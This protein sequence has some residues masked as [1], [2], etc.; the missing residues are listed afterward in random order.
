MKRTL[1]IIVF[2]LVLAHTAAVAAGFSV[3]AEADDLAQAKAA[4]SARGF[5]P[6]DAS[7]YVDT[8]DLRVILAEAKGPFASHAPEMA[9]FFHDGLYLGTDTLHPSDSVALVGSSS[10]EVTLVYRTW[11]PADAHCC[12]TGPTVHVRFDWTGTR[13]VPVDPI[14]TDAQ[15]YAWTSITPR[16]RGS[17][18][19]RSGDLR[20]APVTLDGVGGVVP[21]MTPQQ[22]A[23]RWGVHVSLGPAVASPG[24]QTATITKR[25]IHGYAL[26]EGGRFGAIFFDRGA[27]TPSGITIGSRVT[28]LLRVYGPRLHVKPHAYVAGGHYYFLTRRQPP[29]WRLRFDSNARGIITQIVFG[30]RAAGYIEGCA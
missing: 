5:H 23:V 3:G 12:P 19:T 28:Q 26:F 24:C 22:V 8:H 10:R 1:L 4:V 20:R 21:G 11:N 18:S 16:L 17:T 27:R 7:G 30:G 25:P 14:P 29:H 6:Y 2:G 15:R 9:F 13:V